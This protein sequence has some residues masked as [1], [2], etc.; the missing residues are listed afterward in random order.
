MYSKGE[1]ARG[2]GY[3]TTA[4]HDEGM[5]LIRLNSDNGQL[6]RNFSKR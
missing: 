1:M 4:G 2:A 3:D 5:S 6:F